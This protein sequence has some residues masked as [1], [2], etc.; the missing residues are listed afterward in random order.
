MGLCPANGM[1]N[2]WVFD[3]GPMRHGRYGDL[4]CHWRCRLGLLLPR[5]L[6]IS[7]A[8]PRAQASG[9]GSTARPVPFPLPHTFATS[10]SFLGSRELLL[11]AETNKEH[12]QQNEREA[13]HL[14][15]VEQFPK[16]D[17]RPNQGPDVP[18]RDH[19]VEDG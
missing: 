16:E 7:Q 17:A 6:S 1:K 19:G 15:A 3:R 10:E 4:T 5:D 9:H 8:E 13:G 11:V 14:V 2:R 18:Q 12:A